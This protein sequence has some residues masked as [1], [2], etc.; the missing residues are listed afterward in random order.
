MSPKE[1]KILEKRREELLKEVV[2]SPLW[3]NGS[4]VESKRKQAGKMKPFNYL[5][6]SIKG[7]NKITYVS[8]GSLDAFKEAAAQGVRVRNLLVEAGEITIKLLKGAG[9]NVS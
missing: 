2:D 6:R 8:S 4:V 3:V 9:K 1:R 7:K 5:S